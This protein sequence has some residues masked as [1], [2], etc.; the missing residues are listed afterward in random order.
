MAG[1]D[2]SGHVN[3]RAVAIPGER[4]IGYIEQ[5][6]RTLVPVEDDRRNVAGLVD[7]D[8]GEIVEELDYTPYGRVAV[9]DGTDAESCREQVSDASLCPTT[10]ALGYAGRGARR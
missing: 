1:L 9:S 8:T 2:P 3:W 6:G 10:V 4:G 7:A 5:G